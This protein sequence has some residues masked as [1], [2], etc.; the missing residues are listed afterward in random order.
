MKNVIFHGWTATSRDNW[1]PWMKRELEKKKLEVLIPDLPNTELPQEKEWLR[2]ALKLTAYDEDT[3]VVG[4]SLGSI[5]ILRLLERLKTKVKAVFLVASFNEALDMTELSNFFEKPFNYEKIK[6]TAGKI[7]ILSGDKDPYIPV[8]SPKRLADNLNT[9]LI[10][11]KGGDHLSE[12]TGDCKF[13][14]LRD[15]ILNES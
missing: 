9:R 11:I 1:F 13:P 5:L 6:K 12:G 10:I 14:E 15:M 8:E 4:H 7:Y 2:A 3:I